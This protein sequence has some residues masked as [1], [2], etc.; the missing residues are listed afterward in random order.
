MV[1][2][3]GKTGAGSW[4]MPRRRTAQPLI[5][6]SMLREPMNDSL[7]GNLTLLVFRKRPFFFLSR[8]LFQGGESLLQTVS[9][10]SLSEI[11][12]GESLTNFTSDIF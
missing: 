11:P 4:R 1:Q 7:E 9:S 8:S 2:A 3:G 6:F 12:S 5:I 10:Y